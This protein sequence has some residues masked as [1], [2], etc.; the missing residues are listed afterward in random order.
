MSTS[1]V[2]NGKLD[3]KAKPDAVAAFDQAQAALN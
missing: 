2:A 1:T 3:V